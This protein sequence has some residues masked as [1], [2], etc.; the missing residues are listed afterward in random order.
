MIIYCSFS[1]ILL[2]THYHIS[3]LFA[4]SGFEPT[5]TESPAHADPT[6]GREAQ[7]GEGEQEE[8]KTTG[9]EDYPQAESPH[10]SP[11]PP[12]VPSPSG[13]PPSSPSPELSAP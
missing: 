12:A 8:E 6:A 11:P 1:L 4:S 2:S 10:P 9:P 13:I 5:A 7:K 3:G